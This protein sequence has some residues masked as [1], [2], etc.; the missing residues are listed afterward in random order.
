VERS[1]IGMRKIAIS[2]IHGCNAT[3][4]ALLRQIN[5]SKTDHLFLLGDYLDR[6][7]SSKQV[8]DTIFR[9]KAEGYEV[10]CLRGNHEEMLLWA[11][12]GHRYNLESFLRNGGDTTLASFGVKHPRDIPPHYIDFLENL[13]LWIEADE[14]IFVHAGLHFVQGSSPFDHEDEMLWIRNWY[15]DLDLEWLGQR[16]IV[17]GHT[18]TPQPS[19]KKMF[20][21]FDDLRVINIDAGCVYQRTGYG[22]L[23]AVD[24]SNRILYFEPRHAGDEI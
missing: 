16:Y 17:H 22:Q 4:E 14:Y 19:I 5:F 15:I 10:N 13:P 2:D 24:L 20:Q 7:P 9:L 1:S 6:G 8:L 23:C 21:Q 3:F 18:P 11:L 12:S